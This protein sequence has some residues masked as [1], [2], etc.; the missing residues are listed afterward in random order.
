MVLFGSRA[1]GD[2][3]GYADYDLAVFIKEL[4][5]LSSELDRLVG[6]AVSA[7]TAVWVGTSHGG[8]W[9][10]RPDI[11]GLWGRERS[12][13]RSSRIRV[14][15]VRLISAGRNPDTAARGFA[16]DFVSPRPIKSA[17]SGFA[18]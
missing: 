9:P 2:A 8:R 5:S 15:A 16:I 18:E 17:S 7:G 13:G 10:R 11:E 4:N 14:S 3:R 6:D 12:S 1:R